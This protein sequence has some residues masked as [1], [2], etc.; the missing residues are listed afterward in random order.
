MIVNTKMSHCHWS[1]NELTDQSSV[2]PYLP[3]IGRD[4]SRAVV[5]VVSV[6]E[7]GVLPEQGLSLSERSSS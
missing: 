2:A 3:G 1:D 6:Q 5:V 4:G 7:E